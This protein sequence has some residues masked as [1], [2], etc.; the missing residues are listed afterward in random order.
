[1]VE[2]VAAVLLQRRVVDEFGVARE[3][4]QGIKEFFFCVRV[5]GA[6][7]PIQIG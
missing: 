4:G 1:M 3:F 2:R 7:A 5:A 6:V